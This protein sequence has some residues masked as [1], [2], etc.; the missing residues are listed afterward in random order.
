MR[1][2]RF[3]VFVRNR[4]FIVQSIFWNKK[5]TSINEIRHFDE[6]GDIVAI[7]GDDLDNITLM[8]S[9]NVKE[10]GKD[11]FVFEG[12]IVQIEYKQCVSTCVVEYCRIKCSLILRP[13]KGDKPK[14][15][16]H[17]RISGK[18]LIR[19]VGNI[20]YNPELIN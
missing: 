4:L 5:L 9:T 19:V 15:Q 16:K 12:D 11:T 1:D 2:C 13:L 10:T 17:Y 7:K 6:M 14:N 3:R 18:K 20:F 8:T